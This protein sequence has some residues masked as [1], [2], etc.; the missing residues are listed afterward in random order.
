LRVLLLLT[1]RV[2]I[3]EGVL[4]VVVTVRMEV[5]APPDIV[6]ELSV[7]PNPA[8]LATAGIVTPSFTRPLKPAFGETVTATGLAPGESIE[9]VVWFSARL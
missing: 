1:V 9:I 7:A 4:A 2:K 3:P 8:E 5:P 6:D